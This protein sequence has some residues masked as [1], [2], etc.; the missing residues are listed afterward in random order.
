MQYG[1]EIRMYSWGMLFVTMVYI[2]CIQWLKK[3]NVKYL[4]LMT[5]FTIF[6]IYTH[7]FA[8]VSVSCIYLFLLIYIIKDKNRIKKYILSLASICLA[9]IPWIIIFIKQVL[10]VKESYWINDITL[11]T[12]KR[13]FQY[14]FTINENKFLTFIILCLLMITIILF[15]L[16]RN[17]KNTLYAISGFLI[18]IGTIGI[19]IIVS[20]IIRP[21]FIDR[22]MI[23]SLGCLWLSV[24]IM[25]GNY[26]SKK[27]F[28]L[29]V[30]I[31]SIII[32]ICNTKTLIEKEIIYNKQ[33][34]NLK[35]N[36]DNINNNDNIFVFDSNQLQ[37]VISY[38]YPNK[39]TYV[40][41]KEITELTKR[42]YRQTKMETIDNLQNLAEF[43]KEIYIFTTNETIIKDITDYSYKC[44]KI[45]NYK[46]ERY[47]F[48]I[49]KIENIIY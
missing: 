40:Y 12:A 3:D 18:P 23:C 39:D 46:I 13:L 25:L 38:Y 48:S 7:Y 29:F 27:S 43:E 17:E 14:P 28:F 6:S 8:A 4:I 34:I 1:I 36:I 35:N 31:L 32:C 19:G 44:K 47:I 16:K 42:V 21:V 45:G 20:I 22:Y 5:I 33:H 37:R 24:A 41:G 49:Y 11:D 26:I 2:Y 30:S 15:V 9:Y 10:V